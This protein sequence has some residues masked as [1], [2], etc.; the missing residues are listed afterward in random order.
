MYRVFA[1]CRGNNQLV[2]VKL[3]EANRAFLLAKAV[4]CALLDTSSALLTMFIQVLATELA[5]TAFVAM[6]ATMRR[7]V[8]IEYL[9]FFAEVIAELLLAA[10]ARMTDRLYEATSTAA[11][12]LN[13]ALGDLFVWVESVIALPALEKE[14]AVALVMG[15]P[16]DLTSALKV[17]TTRGKFKL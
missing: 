4:M 8:V 17:D 9:A 7:I 3:H 2:A 5:S 10:L 13:L 14:F 6:P 11:N 1:V 16:L 15:W 12:A